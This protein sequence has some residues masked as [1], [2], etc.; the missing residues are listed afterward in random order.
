MVHEPTAVELQ[1]D[2]VLQDRFDQA[3][4]VGALARARSP[5]GELV[6]PAH[7]EYDARIRRTKELLDA[8]APVIFEAAFEAEGVF[9]AVDILE[10]DGDS[11]TMT[12]VKSASSLKEEHIPD[13]AVQALV[14]ERNGVRP[15]A[16]KVMH[17]S[18]DF[19]H[20]DRGDLFAEEDVTSE[21]ANA[22]PG[23]PA[24]IKAQRSMLSGPLPVVDI[25]RHCAEPRDCPFLERCWPQDPDHIAKLFNVGKK[26]Y[27]EY[28][29]KGITAISQ[30]PITQKLQFPQRRQVRAMRE[31]RL[32]VEPGL[33]EALAPFSGRLGFL[34][35]E[36]ISRAVPVWDG[37]APWEQAAAQFSYHE[38]QAGGTYTH[39]AFLAEGP[40]DARPP[41]AKAMLEATAHAERVVTYT[42]FEKTR[43]RGLQEALPELAPDLLALE[44]KLIDL[45]PIIRDYVYDPRFL[46]SFSI[47]AVLHPLVP[48]LTYKDLVIVDGLVA[49]V[50]IARLLFVADKIRPDERD[51]VRQDLLDYCERDTWAM[52]RVLEVLK[53]LAGL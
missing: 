24:E 52:V 32:I 7:G 17:L 48:E 33:K 30:I 2:K 18:K 4:Q 28:A 50:E 5:R 9:A 12:E 51:R 1:P 45:H 41:L 21:V 38:R 8:K 6:G 31:N 14:L 49:S 22:L 13:A 36:T 26:R 3:A 37:M 29:R 34:D 47:K 11:F 43:I 15:T 35:F 46:G 16:I 42:S 25:G 23:I 19:R 44:N 27:V 39:Q 10:R 40:N 20:P 53:G